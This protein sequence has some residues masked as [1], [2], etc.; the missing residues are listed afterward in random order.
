MDG[1]LRRLHAEAARRVGEAY[2]PKSRGPLNT[3]LRALAEFAEQCPERELFRE[4]GVGGDRH[5]G[6]WN[7]WTFVLFAVWM[8][9]R[10]SRQTKKPVSAATIESYVSLLKGYLSYNYDFDLL[11]RAPRLSRLLRAMRESEPG[12]GERRV[13]RGLRRRHLRRMWRRIEWVRADSPTRVNEHALLAVAWQV[14]ARGGE[15]APS[16]KDWSAARCPSRADLTFHTQRK[17]PAYAMVWLRPLKKRGRGL[18]PKVPQI[19]PEYDGQGSDA[20]RA[21]RRLEELDPVSDAQRASTPLFRMQ[22][23]GG[24]FVHITVK[25]MRA[26]VRARMRGLGYAHPSH[27]GAH[28]CRI[29]GATDLMAT[30][31]ASQL[32]LQAKGRWGSD[33]GRIYARLTRQGQIAASSLM[34]TAAGRDLE[35]LLPGFVQPA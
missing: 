11:D 2:A 19:I 22:A 1:L 21:L 7:E 8:A 13:R 27:W 32:L 34:Q 14:L 24:A 31:Q 16:C 26:A 17:G 3:A 10:V 30:G 5:A 4:K 12:S 23:P 15:L 29:G 28:S 6:A 25:H 9:R 18:A 20:Y 33:I 35:E